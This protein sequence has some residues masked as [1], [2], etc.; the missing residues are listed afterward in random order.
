MPVDSFV[1][2]MSVLDDPLASG[3]DCSLVSDD[4]CVVYI[5]LNASV[6]GN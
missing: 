2:G 3:G 1:A 6:S 5:I 4:S